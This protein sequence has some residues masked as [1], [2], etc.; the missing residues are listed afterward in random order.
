MDTEEREI[1]AKEMQR[2]IALQAE[3]GK[4]PREALEALLKFVG[5]E[6]PKFKE[7]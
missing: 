3:E 2:F 7:G 5:G 6:M 4:T 1:T